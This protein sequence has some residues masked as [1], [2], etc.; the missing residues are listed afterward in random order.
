MISINCRSQRGIFGFRDVG[1][2]DWHGYTLPTGQPIPRFIEEL[3]F[4]GTEN[5]SMSGV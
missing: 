5:H 4:C 2:G 1:Q 3:L